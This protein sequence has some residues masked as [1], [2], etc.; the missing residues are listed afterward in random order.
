MGLGHVKNS[1][2]LHFSIWMYLSKNMISRLSELK[3]TPF[4]AHSINTACLSGRKS[5][6]KSH[7]PIAAVGTLESIFMS[8]T[9]CYNEQQRDAEHKNSFSSLCD[10]F[11]PI[12]FAWWG[13]NSSH[14]SAPFM[15][16]KKIGCRL[17]KTRPPHIIIDQVNGST[18]HPFCTLT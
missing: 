1:K 18:S 6:Q 2:S 14:G 12:Y 17:L 9:I 15:F 13:Y 10:F 8:T 5:H 11:A 7:V 3:V 16:F 4:I